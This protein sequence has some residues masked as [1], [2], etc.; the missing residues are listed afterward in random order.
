MK[1]NADSYLEIPANP[2]AL[3]ERKFNGAATVGRALS[4]RVNT[5]ALTGMILGQTNYIEKAIELCMAAVRQASVGD[6]EKA[7]GHLSVGDGLHAYAVAYDWLYNYLD[8]SQREELYAEVLEFSK[9]TYDY[10]MSGTGYGRYDPVPLSCNHNVVSHAPLGLAALLKGDQ[11][12]W[13]KRAVLF[14]EG[15]FYY[16]TD[17]S[18]WSYEGISY[19]GYG[20][21]NAIPFVAAYERAGNRNLLA[22]FKKIEQTPEWVLRFTQPWGG[23]VVALND[24]RNELGTAGGLMYLIA[25]NKD[26]TGLWAFLKI[27][28]PD[29]LGTY[30]GPY[31]DYIGNGC[32]LPYVILFADPQ[33]EPLHP[34]EA[35]LPLGK[36]FARGGGSF[37]SSW[38]DDAA[39]ATFTCGFDQHRGHNHKDENSFTLSAFGE[40]FVIDPEYT[41]NETRF[42]NTVLVNGKGQWY[43]EGQYDVCG[44][45]IETKDF[46]EAW[47]MKGNA[48]GAYINDIGLKKA[49][50]KFL[51]AKAPQPYIVVSDDITTGTEADFDWLLHTEPDNLITI[52]DDGK[53]FTI[54]AA[55]TNS[56][57]CS[58]RFLA[59][60]E[61]LRISETDLRREFYDRKGRNYAVASFFKEIRAFY[62]GI[63]P[64]FT[65]LLVA[66]RNESELPEITVSNDAK[67]ITVL[68]RDGMMDTVS[69]AGESLD[70]KRTQ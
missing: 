13:L 48:S 68:F 39:L 34:K 42:H 11:P 14:T 64:G 37:R 41:P 58:G 20:A 56:A 46:G 51:F 43:E 4:E 70:F 63:N 67:T 54:H 44:E 18:G 15:Y 29:G 24:S 69:L 47:Y 35:N 2:Y 62:T 12:D 28:G 57:V 59:P 25:E 31:T 23:E 61:G 19:Y 52:G 60:S 36:F 65:V 16:G 27:Y 9:W 49:T 17:D 8:D 33:L 5:L 38:E 1:N 7:N 10:S 3:S 30:G 45:T 66:A 21:N 40:Y 32:T 53:S 26:R 50:R 22:S 55:G 6:F